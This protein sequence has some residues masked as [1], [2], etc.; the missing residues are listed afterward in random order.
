MPKEVNLRFSGPRAQTA[1]RG[2]TSVHERRL[3]TVEV[4]LS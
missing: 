2:D 4:G 3:P 1:G